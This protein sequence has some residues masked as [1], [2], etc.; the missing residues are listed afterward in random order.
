MHEH[1]LSEADLRY[2]DLALET[3]IEAK[4]REDN[5]EG[6]IFVGNLPFAWLELRNKILDWEKQA[7]TQGEV[8]RVARLAQREQGLIHKLSQL[9]HAGFR[10]GFYRW[11]RSE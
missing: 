5:P 4:E 10:R 6:D 2:L 1:R 11:L 7:T 9:Y 8:M 3:A